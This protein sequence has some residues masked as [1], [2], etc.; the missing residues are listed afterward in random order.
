VNSEFYSALVAALDCIVCSASSARRFA[1]S[2]RIVRASSCL[3]ALLDAPSCSH[4][5]FFDFWWVVRLDE[6]EF[7]RRDEATNVF[8]DRN[9]LFLWQLD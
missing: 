9:R 6:E 1:A 8:V 4:L 3:H 2:C 5:S 7:S